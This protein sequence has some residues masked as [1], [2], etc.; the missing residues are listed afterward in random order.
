MDILLAKSDNSHILFYSMSNQIFKEHKRYNE[1]IEKTQ[2]G[3]GDITEYLEW[4]LNC[5]KRALQSS[6]K[7]LGIILDKSHF[8]N[9][10][11]FIVKTYLCG[12]KVKFPPQ[13]LRWKLRNY[14]R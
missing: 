5:F 4:F 2:K 1:V 7:N 3:S 9:K 10:H 8:W 12:K 13:N 6:N 14:S 11:K